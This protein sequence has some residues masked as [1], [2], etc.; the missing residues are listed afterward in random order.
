[1]SLPE[2][3]PSRSFGDGDFTP[4]TKFGRLCDDCDLVCSVPWRGVWDAAWQM[5]CRH[6]IGIPW[7]N[8][9]GVQS[10]W[11]GVPCPRTHTS[12]VPAHL[13][14]WRESALGEKPGLSR[15][16]ICVLRTDRMR[17]LKSSRVDI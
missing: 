14:I 10:R 11:L 9:P 3:L 8:R 15:L 6:K 13:G 5:W 2:T 1:M 17:G 16:G 4:K 7:T 12:L